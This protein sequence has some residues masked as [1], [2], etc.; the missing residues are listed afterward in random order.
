MCHSI[1]VAFSLPPHP[2][3]FAK[4]TPHFFQHDFSG[5]G[6]DGIIICIGP[7]FEEFLFEFFF[8]WDTQRLLALHGCICRFCRRLW[9]VPLPTL[10]LWTI[11]AWMELRGIPSCF[12][13]FPRLGVVVLVFSRNNISFFFLL[14]LAFS[15]LICFGPHDL[16]DIVLRLTRRTPIRQ[17]YSH[18]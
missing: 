12:C 5:I 8:V 16:G 15:R 14:K 4:Q 7:A 6:M 10:C 13:C 18:M 1:F 17:L 2:I 11:L 3:S 9:I